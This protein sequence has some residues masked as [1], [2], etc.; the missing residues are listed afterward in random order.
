MNKYLRKVKNWIKHWSNKVP[1]PRYKNVTL[2]NVGHYYV[3]ALQHGKIGHRSASISFRFLIALFPLC[4]FLFSVIPFIPIEGLQKNL[5]AGLQNFFPEQIFGFFKE[6][7]DD[8]ITQKKTVLM[9]VGFILSIYFASNAVDA[10]ISGLTASHHVN[11]KRIFWRQK[12]WSLAIL[13]IFFVFFILAFLISS[14][15]QYLIDNY[16]EGSIENGLFYWTFVILQSALSIFLFMFSI[17]ILYNVANTDKVKWKFFNAGAMASTALI[18]ILKLT[19]GLYI[20]Y[21]GKFD[22]IYG[23]I[24]TGLAFLL[25]IFY[26]FFLLIIGFELNTSLDKA[27]KYKNGRTADVCQGNL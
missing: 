19:F 5:M 3:E 21:F 9:S 15:G 26:I 23:P 4:I 2:Y 16:Y 22:Q 7:L 8:L 11:T 10:L 6:V 24:G 13:F 25:F 14:L 27:F 18:I 1:I 20:T 17:S 12:L